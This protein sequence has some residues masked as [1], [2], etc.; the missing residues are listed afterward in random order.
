MGSPEKRGNNRPEEAGE[1]LKSLFVSIGIALVIRATV[2]YPYTIPTGSMDG[3]LLV[4]DFIMAN[5]FVYGLRSPDWIGIPYT[6]IGFGVPSFRTGGLRAPEQ[7][8]VVIFRY[9]RS[10][11]DHYVK[12]CI[13]VSGDTVMIR[14]RVTYVNDRKFKDTPNTKFI[15]GRIIP[16]GVNQPDIF[17]PGAG[18][19]HQYG[20]I[21]VPA[22]GDSFRF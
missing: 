2:I 15:L 16:Q 4:G 12:R 18:N 5:K 19:I 3:S 6:N 8:D 17:P 10:E 21:R 9:P 22:P 7:G 13:A 1:F 11:R 14:D 20:P